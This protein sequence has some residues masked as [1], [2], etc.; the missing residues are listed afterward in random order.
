MEEIVAKD[1]PYLASYKNVAL[2]FDKIS[3]AK[4]PEAF[5]VRYLSDTLGLKST[6]DRQLISLLKKM[7][8]LDNSGKPTPTFSSLKNAGAAKFAIANGVRTAYAPL[9]ESDE[10]IHNVASDQLKGTIAQVSGAEEGVVKAITGTFNALV[11]LADFSGNKAE[12]IEKIEEEDEEIV[13]ED[14]SRPL[15]KKVLTAGFSP[16]FRFNIEIHLPS[17][18][19]EETYLNIFNALRKT[20]G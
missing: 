8:F 1:L 14:E 17:N 15:R 12:Q 2:L 9:Y 18:G 16:S 19:T 11:K 13:D 20:L 3:K 7:G 5:T 10:N 4:V 6:G